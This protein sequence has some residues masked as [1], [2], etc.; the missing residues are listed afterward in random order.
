MG[1]ISRLV[2]PRSVRRAIH[3]VRTVKRAATPPAVKQAQHALH[4]IDNAVYRVERSLRA[5]HRG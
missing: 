3:P 5:K 2:V 1:F 4:P